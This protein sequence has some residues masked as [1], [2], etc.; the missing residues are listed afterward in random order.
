[1]LAATKTALPVL[2]AG[3]GDGDAKKKAASA[4]AS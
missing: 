4:A 3:V 1:M 2:R